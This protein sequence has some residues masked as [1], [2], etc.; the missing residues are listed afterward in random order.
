[1]APTVSD[2]LAQSSGDL[3]CQYW[4]TATGETILTRE[5]E[6]ALMSDSGIFVNIDGINQKQFAWSIAGSFGSAWLETWNESMGNIVERDY[7]QTYGA[8]LTVDAQRVWNILQ[9]FRS[10]PATES[11]AKVVSFRVESGTH[12]LSLSLRK[13]SN[14]EMASGRVSTFFSARSNCRKCQA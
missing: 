5:I 4:P 12:S 13:G 9:D 10:P 8:I 11:A 7:G 2:D 1:M 3:H 6:F 14:R